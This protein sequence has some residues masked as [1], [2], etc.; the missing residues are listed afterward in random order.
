MRTKKN[1]EINIKISSKSNTRRIFVK[2]VRIQIFSFISQISNT[3][4][5]DWYEDFVEVKNI[6][7]ILQSW[8]ETLVTL[9]TVLSTFLCPRTSTWTLL[10][11][12]K[13][14]FPSKNFNRI[15]GNRTIIQWHR[16]VSMLRHNGHDIIKIPA[17]LLKPIISN[18]RSNAF[19]TSV[20]ARVNVY[21][22]L[23]VKLQCKEE[24]CRSSD[25]LQRCT[26]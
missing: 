1:K 22:P 8:F 3:K 6:V 14:N 20:A 19:E 21:T 24:R 11:G 10:H 23:L 2:Q 7:K 5:E 17:H 15:E 16:T 18:K 13:K 12:R 25:R 4:W 26:V 9:S